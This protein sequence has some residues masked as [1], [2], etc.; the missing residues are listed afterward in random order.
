MSICS[1]SVSS[2]SDLVP[3]KQNKRRKILQHMVTNQSIKALNK[4]LYIGIL[5]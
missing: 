4:K 1:D 2:S 5:I 3:L